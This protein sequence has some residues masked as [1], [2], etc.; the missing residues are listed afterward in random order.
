LLLL[1]MVVPTGNT[2]AY[3]KLLDLLKLVY[4]GGR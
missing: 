4:A 1:E 3:A 2:P